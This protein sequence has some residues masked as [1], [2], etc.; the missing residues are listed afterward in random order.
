MKKLIL[1]VTLGLFLMGILACGGGKYADAISLTE[2]AVDAME[3]YC[4]GLEKADNAKD[5]AAVINKFSDTMAA[6]KPK[7]DELQKKY[8]EL[9]NNK[10]V[11]EEMKAITKRMEEVVPKMMGA[12]AKMMK[13]ATDPA[14][15]EAT[16]KMQEA[17]AK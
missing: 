11:P 13:Y 2:E 10:D 5:V 8:P 12:S 16:K 14:V 15:L 3:N 7:M 17:M 4:T 6:L 1:L 9:K